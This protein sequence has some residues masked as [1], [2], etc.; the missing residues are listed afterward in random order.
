MPQPLH[1]YDRRVWGRHKIDVAFTALDKVD[2]HADPMWCDLVGSM[3]ERASS[4][5]CR[6]KV[7]TAR[8][9]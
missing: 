2:G 1:I 3:C 6:T 7:A 9:R 8:T 5:G 4:P